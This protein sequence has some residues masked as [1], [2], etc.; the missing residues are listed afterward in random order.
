MRAKHDIFRLMMTTCW[1][2]VH[3]D[4]MVDRASL[5][6]AKTVNVCTVFISFLHILIMHCGHDFKTF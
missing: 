2:L 6:I 5:N 3:F 4:G 1:C